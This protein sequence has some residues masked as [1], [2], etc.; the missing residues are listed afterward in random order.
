MLHIPALWH[1]DISVIYPQGFHIVKFVE[2]PQYFIWQQYLWN[3]ALQL[4]VSCSAYKLRYVVQ[5]LT[6]GEKNNCETGLFQDMAK[7]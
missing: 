3:I 7:I 6:A 5:V 4:A 1:F 2:M